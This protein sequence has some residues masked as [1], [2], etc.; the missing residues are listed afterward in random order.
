MPSSRGSSQ[1]RD[2][3]LCLLHWQADS[4][5]LSHWRSPKCFSSHLDSRHY[6]LHLNSEDISSWIIES[7]GTNIF[8]SP[9][10]LLSKREMHCRALYFRAPC[11]L[12]L[13]PIQPQPCQSSLVPKFH[14]ALALHMGKRHLSPGMN[15]SIFVLTMLDEKVETS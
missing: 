12:E 6:L 11:F 15:G 9:I 1:P 4:L 7:R 2:P 10:Y 5:P 8:V 14:R 3:I 13:P